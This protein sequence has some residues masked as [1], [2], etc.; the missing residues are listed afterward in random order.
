M[1]CLGY[2]IVITLHKVDINNNNNKK[3]VELRNTCNSKLG[4]TSCARKFHSRQWGSE[5][6]TTCTAVLRKSTGTE[7]NLHVSAVIIKH[8]LI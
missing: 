5:M 3:S 2:I 1:V 6:C 8:N 7:I 4:F